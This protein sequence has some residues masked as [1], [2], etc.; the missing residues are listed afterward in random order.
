MCGSALT[1]P[2]TRPMRSDGTLRLLDA[3]RDSGLKVKFYQAGSSEMFEKYWKH[4]KKNQRLFIRASL[5]LRES[6]AH[7]I[8][9]N[10]REAY[11][12]LSATA[13]V[14]HESRAGAGL[15]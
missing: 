7:N 1:C 14:H 13:F 2:N 10:Y 4:H 11:N 15:L 12:M 3:I 9:V 6:F 8:C 5:R